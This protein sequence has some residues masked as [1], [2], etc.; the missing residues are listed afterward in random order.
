MTIAL[1]QREEKLEHQQQLGHQRSGGK[2]LQK[3]HRRRMVTGQVAAGK[4]KGRPRFSAAAVT[5]EADIASVDTAVA[6]TA[7]A[8][9]AAAGTA[10]ADTHVADTVA[11]DTANADTPIADTVAVERTAADSCC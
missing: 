10:T 11:A 8:D 7:T 5:V 2:E 9:T 6:D 4:P 3:L 1:Y